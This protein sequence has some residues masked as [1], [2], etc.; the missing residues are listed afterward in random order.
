MAV[1]S[2]YVS[3]SRFLAGGITVGPEGLGSWALPLSLTMLLLLLRGASAQPDPTIIC[4]GQ[5][6]LMRPDSQYCYLYYASPMDWIAANKTCNRTGGLLTSITSQEE[7]QYIFDRYFTESGE[8]EFWIGL[9][10]LEQE[11]VFKWVG[12]DSAELPY[13]SWITDYTEDNSPSHD[14]VKFTAPGWQ[15]ENPGFCGSTEHPFVCKMQTCE[16]QDGTRCI[17]EPTDEG[18]GLGVAAIVGILLGIIIF[19]VILGVVIG[20]VLLWKFKNDAFYTYVFC[21]AK[22]GSR[23]TATH[24]LQQENQR[25]RHEL[26]QHKLSSSGR[27]SQGQLGL[28]DPLNASLSISRPSY[29]TIHED[30][31][32]SLSQSRPSFQPPSSRIAPLPSAPPRF[33]LGGPVGVKQF[34]P[35]GGITTIGGVANSRFRSTS[36]PVPSLPP[37]LESP[38][39][40]NGNKGLAIATVKEEDEEEEGE[41]AQG[42]ATGSKRTSNN[43]TQNGASEKKNEGDSKAKEEEKGEKA[44]GGKDAISVSSVDSDKAK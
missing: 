34:P 15:V 14:C 23:G 32:L 27:Y 6:Y 1:H 42:G 39:K 37:L 3:G 40:S 2:V 19:V 8:I 24:S 9:S 5:D 26:S 43:E 41:K 31:Q 36:L 33:G 25:L 10:D 12:N 16:S 30:R 21:C 18:G 17:S 13:T 11:G 35:L 4:G 28:G 22:G 44:E 29:P 20:L 38:N 7:N